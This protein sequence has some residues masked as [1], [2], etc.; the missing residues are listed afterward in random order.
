MRFVSWALQ[1]LLQPEHRTFTVAD[2]TQ[3]VYDIQL[4]LTHMVGSNRPVSAKHCNRYCCHSTNIFSHCQ[5]SLA[6]STASDILPDAA[7]RMVGC[8]SHIE[9]VS[10]ESCNTFVSP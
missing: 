3:A 9:A 4:L 1:Q 10:A 8:D 5:Q 6:G 2:F 7:G